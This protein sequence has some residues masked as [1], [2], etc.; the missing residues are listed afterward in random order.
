MA[1]HEK[2]AQLGNNRTGLAMS[3]QHGPEIVEGAKAQPSASGDR[4]T[5]NVLKTPYVKEQTPVGSVPPP[6]SVK[7][8]AKTAFQMLKGENPTLL[9]D[10]LGERLAFERTG[11]RL[12]EAVIAKAE[13]LPASDT[14]PSLAE[15]KQIRDEELRHFHMVKGYIENL[16]GDP[17]AMTP[18][19][20]VSAVA[21]MGLL[22]V[23]ADPRITV[24]QSLQALLIA[25]LA[26]N[27][28]WAVLINL[29]E[30][31]GQD[32]MAADFRSALA[33]EERHLAKVRGWLAASV[34]SQAGVAA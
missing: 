25:E 13:S 4:Y 32:Q 31:F 2:S 12:Y 20:D 9:V 17:T 29:A 3:P 24:V 22:Q 23:V 21:S 27:D 7:G 11:T 1:T 19:A 33:A 8:M 34:E 30:G 10:K 14:G 15:L 6:L 16:G 18:C 28:G 5:Q 26:D